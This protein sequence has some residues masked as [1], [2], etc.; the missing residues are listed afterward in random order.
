[1]MP[2]PHEKGPADERGAADRLVVLARVGAPHGVRGAVR[3]NVFAED[4]LSLRRYNP[5]VGPSGERLKLL[6]VKP[7]GKALIATFEG[8]T[9]RT[10]A[11]A[12]RNRDLAVPRSRLPRPDEGE[13][14][15]VD[16][17][18]LEARHVDGRRLGTVKAVNDFGAGELLEIDGPEGLLVPFTMAAVPT[19]D[20]V[21]G[22]LTVDPPVMVEADAGD[23]GGNDLATEEPGSVT[24]ETPVK[25]DRDGSS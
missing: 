15:H 16:L 19:V 8:V 25:K 22:F 4:P 5:F 11:E 10:A 3:L 6:S 23:V 9:D 13:F 21:G 17:I 24:L 2:G 12:L 1:M 7:S 20:V 14:Y 18:G